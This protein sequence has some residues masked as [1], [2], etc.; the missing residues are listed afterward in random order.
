[1]RIPLIIQHRH[2]HLSA[3]DFFALFGDGECTAQIPIGHHGQ[4]VS[5]L[6]VDV[7]GDFG[8]LSNVC[9]LGPFRE[10]TQVE[11]S[12]TEAVA[13]G[14]HA[15]VRVSGDTK[16][17]ASCILKSQHATV[18]IPSAVIIPARH[19]HLNEQMAKRAGLKHGQVVRVQTEHDIPQIISHVTV[20]VHP[21][22]A[23]ELHVMVDEAA[24]YWMHTGQYIRLCE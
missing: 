6:S 19:L 14:L 17:S 24:P 2:V 12:V 1:M 9:I 21:S 15:P 18:K 7:Y 20:R 16:R 10:H 13:I 23:T 22:F 4:F 3:L 5:N 11:L 8:Y